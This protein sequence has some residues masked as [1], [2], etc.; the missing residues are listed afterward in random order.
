MPWEIDS[1]TLVC[2]S[3]R[4]NRYYLNPTDEVQFDLA[5]NLSSA[6]IDWDKSKLDK[7]F[8]IDKFNLLKKLNEWSNYKP[9]IYD[10]DEIWGHLDAFRNVVKDED[11][12]DAYLSLC[13]N[14]RFHNSLLFYFF[15]SMESVNTDKYIINPQVVK[16][17]DNSWDV[18]VN[19]NYIHIPYENHHKIDCFTTEKVVNDNISKIELIENNNLEDML[20]KNNSMTIQTPNYKWAGWCD[21]FSSKLVDLIMYPDHWK[22]YGPMDTLWLNLLRQLMGDNTLINPNTNKTPG[23][24]INFKH[25]VLKNQIATSS[26][27]F[28][29]T[30]NF[31]ESRLSLK[32]ERQKQRDVI[33]ENISK[34]HD[35]ILIRI[36]KE[37]KND[38]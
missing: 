4:R 37:W 6:I 25:Y 12:C 33:E 15:R 22:G 26:V 2:E 14:V 1:G 38:Q 13:P 31:Y 27:D 18:L 36:I 23:D 34:D 28:D 7:Q 21:I 24:W 35:T 19:E 11:E 29:V 8:F 20:Y 16:L 30:R 3:L 5:L 10:G 9:T 32:S 17:W